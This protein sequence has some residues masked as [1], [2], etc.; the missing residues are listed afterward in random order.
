MIRSIH[1]EL[2][3]WVLGAL[4]IGASLLIA[5]SYQVLRRNAGESHTSMGT[6]FCTAGATE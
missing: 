2:L 4:G 6:C 1:R 3:A 5:A